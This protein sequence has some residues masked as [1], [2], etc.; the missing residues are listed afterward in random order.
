MARIRKPRTRVRGRRQ[1]LR[2][3]DERLAQPPHQPFNT[4]PGDTLL[5]SDYLDHRNP[6]TV[7]PVLDPPLGDTGYPSFEAQRLLSRR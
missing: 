4:F 5:A 1:S 2:A 6:L 7:G 3:P